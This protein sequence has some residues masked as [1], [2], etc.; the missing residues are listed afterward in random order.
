VRAALAAALAGLVTTAAA[1]GGDDGNDKAKSAGTGGQFSAKIDNP[2][3]PLA[4][5]PV[6]VLE[7]SEK[8]DK[9]K[10]VKTRAVNRVREPG[11]IAGEPVTVVDVREY[12]DGELVEHTRDYYSQR[13]DGSVWY[14]G[15]DVTNYEGGKVAGHEGQWRAGRHNAKPGLFLPGNPRVGQSFEQE[16]A[17]GVAEDSSTIVS[18]DASVETPAGRFSRCLKTR[19][20]SPLDKTSEFKFYCRG[21]GL[22]REVER[23][24]TASL[25]RYG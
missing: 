2:L 22:V 23:V 14:F 4:S 6:S 24:G 12:E 13:S 17:P 18:V 11:R 7:G 1:C 16:R 21:V 10:R 3:F 15:E 20:Y 19:D 9:G 25:V 5:V 8:G